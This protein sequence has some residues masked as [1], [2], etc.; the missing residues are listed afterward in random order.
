MFR[1]TRT[2]ILGAGLVLGACS[3]PDGPVTAPDPGARIEAPPDNPVSLATSRARHERFAR[4]MARALRDPDFRGRVYRAINGS[5]YPEQ[6]VHLQAFLDADGGA[7]RREM[8]NLVSEAGDRISQDL[9]GGSIEMYFPVPAHR[10]H[11]RGGPDLLVATAEL[12]HDAPV[13]FDL[14]GH[15]RRLDPDRPPETPV[16]MVSQAELDFDAGPAA[17]TCLMDCDAGGGGG[18][19]SV[20][21]GPTGS[22]LFM[23]RSR[24][25]NDFEGWFKG[26]PEFEI[27]VL[28]QDGNGS[29]LTSYQCAGEHAGGPYTFDQNGADW[30]G[31]VMLFSQA[32]L[33]A[34]HQQHPGKSLVIFV[35]EDDD[36]ACQIKIDSTRTSRLLKEVSQAYSGLT[37]GK[38]STL[39]PAQKVFKYAPLLYYAYKAVSSVIQ[40][41]DDPVGNAVNDVGAASAYLAGANWLIR[42]E[43]SVVN[44]AL[45]LEMH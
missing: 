4:R 44:G 29:A 2:L 45:R 18:G 20:A 36:T 10:T 33:D 17:L 34:Y 24:I 40:T 37:A 1:F 26:N 41:N 31:S 25:P 12:D 32:Q 35:V 30:T 21:T 7:E 19:G 11:W 3:R 9:A 15:E 23:T 43:N 39:S 14:Q 38:D 27:H 42:G 6:K 5:R 16:L 28:G 22:G 13:A 8:A